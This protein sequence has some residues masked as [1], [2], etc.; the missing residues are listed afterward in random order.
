M[1]NW[2]YTSPVKPGFHEV[3]T[4]ENSDCK[5]SRFY[6][7]N[8][9]AGSSYTLNSDNL[10]MNL[11]VIQGRII[12]THT[13]LRQEMKKLDSLYIPGKTLIKIKALEDS[14]CYIGGAPYEGIG[15]LF[16]RPID[17]SLPI[18]N[19]H[20]IHG[21]SPYEREVFMTVDTDLPAS[22]LICGY[23]W[24]REGAWTSWPPHQHEK[25][26]E[27]IYCYFDMSEHNY[28]LHLSYSNPGTLPHVYP[29]RSGDAVIAPSGY[30]PTVAIPGSRNIYFWILAAFCNK[31]R[32]YDLAKSDTNFDN[33]IKQ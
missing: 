6:R 10:E 25:Y 33:V 12:I 14:F 19:I 32:R 20:Q 21:K 8:L 26:L 1:K 27:E 3:I 30:H 23:T 2:K 15:E 31:S 28:G 24:S 9:K 17:L 16:Y 22:R 4:P 5:E 13:L 29:V 18:G 11:A 7:L